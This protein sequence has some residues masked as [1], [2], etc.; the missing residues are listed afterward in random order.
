MEDIS[1]T[2][3][4]CDRPE[5]RFDFMSIA[6]LHP[7]NFKVARTAA[8]WQEERVDSPCEG[9]VSAIEIETREKRSY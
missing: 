6:E 1:D 5:H 7:I 2:E 3:K 8:Q 4:P 9:N